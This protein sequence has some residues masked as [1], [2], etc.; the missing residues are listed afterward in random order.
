MFTSS[1]VACTLM[2]REYQIRLR[3][4]HLFLYRQGKLCVWGLGRGVR[5]PLRSEQYVELLEIIVESEFL[6]VYGFERI[7]ERNVFEEQHMWFSS[8]HIV[9]QLCS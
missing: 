4:V 8:P 2:Y 1:R 9:V 6:L 7:V 3:S 5:I